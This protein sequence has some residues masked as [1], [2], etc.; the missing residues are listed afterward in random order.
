[1]ASGTVELHGVALTFAVDDPAT[2]TFLMSQDG[3]IQATAT[4]P[5]QA[6]RRQ[7]LLEHGPTTLELE[8][9][10][11]GQKPFDATV[12]GEVVGSIA[13]AGRAG[14]RAIVDLTASVPIGVQLFAAWLAIRDW[15]HAA[16]TY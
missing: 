7:Y 16:T 10:G 9:H 1:M 15:N 4:R 12:G 6:G 8:V 11:I 3:H 14:R 2:G 13:L 5:T